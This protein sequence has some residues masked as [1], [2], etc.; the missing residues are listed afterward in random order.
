MEN[1]KAV[2]AIIRV[3][4]SENQGKIHARLED[5]CPPNTPFAI[6]FNMRQLVE[7]EIEEFRR[8]HHRSPEKPKRARR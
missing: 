7:L 4:V 3:L 8:E 5:A 1:L 2:G 6:E